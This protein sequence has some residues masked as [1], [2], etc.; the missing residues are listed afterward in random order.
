M[1][2]SSTVKK[3]ISDILQV[4]VWPVGVYLIFFI[5]CHVLHAG[6]F[7]TLSSIRMVVIQAIP[8]T[9][10][11]WGMSGNMMSKRWDFS[12]GNMMILCCLAGVPI[13]QMIPSLG[14]WGVLIFVVL[15]GA[16]FG[17][18]NGA[19]YTTLKIPSLLIS[20][21]MMKVYECA[22]YIIR[23]GRP[24]ELGGSMKMFGQMP[25]CI[26]VLVIGAL[27]YYY[28]YFCSPYGKNYYALRDGQ[29]IA[30]NNHINE[31]KNALLSFLF[32]GIFVGL[33]AVVYSGM[34]GIVESSPTQNNAMNMM[35]GAF[36]PIFIGRY[37]SRHC[38]ITIGIFVGSLT[39][40]L[41]TSGIVAVGLPSPMQNVGNGAFLILFMAISANQDRINDWAARRKL[42]AALKAENAVPAAK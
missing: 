42:A 18:L 22:G 20:V 38:N 16:L 24:A 39:M 15:F 33:G 30:V 26:I 25:W 35:C 17:L 19:L 5:L 1:N 34:S 3:G 10:L 7:G 8:T 13:A 12:V 32:M 2:K 27:L 40:K 14:V 23:D 41:L 29:G 21:G 6:K 36:A 4:I 31:K 37:L 11:A 28:L 9:F